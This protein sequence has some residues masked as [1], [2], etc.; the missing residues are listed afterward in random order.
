LDD[1]L[2]DY[3][4]TLKFLDKKTWTDIYIFGVFLAFLVMKTTS[5]LDYNGDCKPTITILLII[6]INYQLINYLPASYMLIDYHLLGYK[7][8]D[9][10]V[11]K[12][13]KKS[14]FNHVAMLN[15]YCCRC[16]YLHSSLVYMGKV[17]N[18]H[19]LTTYFLHHFSLKW[20][21]IETSHL[22][23]LICF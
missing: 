23:Y 16:F 20:C 5:L 13:L 6:I 15:C 3:K 19:L 2:I 22:Y 8:I 9:K 18:N 1:S 11:L 4:H 14:Y 17:M 12:I 10:R 21:M 7:P